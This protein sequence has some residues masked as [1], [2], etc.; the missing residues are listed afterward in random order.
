[1]GIIISLFSISIFI[2]LLFRFRPA[3]GDFFSHS[4][5]PTY[6]LIGCLL[7]FYNNRNRL[8]DWYTELLSGSATGTIVVRRLGC[9]R[10]VV[11]V[12]PDNVEYILTTHFV[13]FPKGKPFTEILGD[14]LGCGIFNVDGELWRTQRKL[15]SHEFSAKSLQEFVVETLESE[16]EMRLLPALETSSR[17]GAVVD[18]QDLLKRFAFGVIGKVVL[19]SEEETIL[20]L[21]KSFD[22]ASK[23][24]AG[25]AM[26]PVYMIWKVKRWFGVGSEWRLKTAVAEVHRKVKNIIEKRREKKKMEDLHER[27]DLLSRLI[28]IGHDDEMIR[29]MAISF[30]MAGRDTTSAAMTWLFWLLSHH[31]NIQ[32]QLVEEIDSESTFRVEQKLD[33]KSLK[34]LK[35]LK[36]CLCETMRMYPPVPWDSKH[37]IADDH[38]PDGTVVQAGDRVTYFPYGMGRME[39]LWGKDWFEFKPSRWL[40]EPD[41]RGWR[42]GVK[43]VSPYKFPIFQAGPRVCLGKE[44]AFIQMKYVVASILSQFRI[45]PIA[46]DH[47]V[48]VPLLTAHMAGGF[49]VLCQRR[50]KEERERERKPIQDKQTKFPI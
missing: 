26:E 22:E 35:F 28:L 50:E 20:E 2:F 47:P 17:D 38:L 7:S 3:A 29:D 18:L 37:A 49:K 5:P 36:A 25:R 9:R 24:S 1:M 32:N 11:T 16:V 12:N 21:E 14:F 30:I 33:Y 40:L 44:M 23:V 42:R 15:A 6:P 10:T 27:K 13:N 45:K 41:G 19:G 46:A 8:L 48:F 34:E 43:L 39:C 4:S 31:L